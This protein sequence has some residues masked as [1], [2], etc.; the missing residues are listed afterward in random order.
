[1]GDKKSFTVRMAPE[2]LERL[3]RARGLIPR[4]RFVRDAIEKHIDSLEG[5]E[6]PERPEAQLKEA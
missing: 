4:E 3:D 2:E 5:P 1:M 6:A